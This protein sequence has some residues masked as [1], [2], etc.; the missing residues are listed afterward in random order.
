MSTGSYGAVVVGARCADAPTATLLARKGYRVP[1]LDKASFPSDAMSK[2][3]VHPRE[4]P[5][6]NDGACWSG[7]RRPAAPGREL[8]LRL[9]AAD[10]LTVLPFAWP[11]GN[12]QA[13]DGFI[14]VQAATLPAPEFFAPANVGRILTEAGTAG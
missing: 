3:L 7:S 12:Q 13:M 6:S 4:W 8:V 11:V 2:H 9:R 14:S 5:R 10:D 1:L